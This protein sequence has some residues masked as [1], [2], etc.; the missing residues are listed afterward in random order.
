MSEFDLI[1]SRLDGLDKKIDEM[2]HNFLKFIQIVSSEQEI[3]KFSAVHHIEQYNKLDNDLADP[4]YVQIFKQQLTLKL[5]S[6]NKGLMLSHFMTDRFIQTHI[7]SVNKTDKI[8][9]FGTRLYS[10]IYKR[11]LFCFFFIFKPN[12]NNILVLAL[13]LLKIQD[14]TCLKNDVRNQIKDAQNRCRVYKNRDKKSLQDTGKT[15]EEDV[16]LLMHGNVKHASGNPIEEQQKCKNK[17]AQHTQSHLHKKNT[18][19]ESHSLNFSDRNAVTDDHSINEP[20]EEFLVEDI[21]DDFKVSDVVYNEN[22]YEELSEEYL[23]NDVDGDIVHTNTHQELK[24]IEKTSNND[25]TQCKAK[26]SRVASALLKTEHVQLSSDSE[27]FVSNEKFIQTKDVSDIKTE[28]TESKDVNHS[29]DHIDENFVNLPRELDQSMN[30]FNARSSIPV[31]IDEEQ[32]ESFDQSLEQK[33]HIK[34]LIFN[35]QLVDQ[36]KP[37]TQKVPVKIRSQTVQNEPQTQ[38]V[39]IKTR[40]QT[41]QIK[42][43]AQPVSRG[44]GRKATSTKNSSDQTSAVSVTIE[45]HFEINDGK[46][47]EEYSPSQFY[48]YCKTNSKKPKVRENK[49]KNTTISYK[50]P[51]KK[52]RI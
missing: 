25:I 46:R 44:R 34:S 32:F 10:K 6:S 40:A 26:N 27:L 15:V 50:S 41:V 51:L 16:G 11:M 39:S 14:E 42:H 33:R 31:Y 52:M 38:K 17:R 24:P 37:P 21:D 2:N 12:L 19:N 35:E 8:N 22:T 20:V 1:M 13:K 45:E 4:F 3:I 5:R 9:I 29:K 30:L 18:L 23:F 43:E 28:V 49:R 7:S 48:P 47:Q 36:E